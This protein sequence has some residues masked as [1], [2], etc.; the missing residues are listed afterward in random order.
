MRT[1]I[2]DMV[3]LYH[4]NAPSHMSFI[5]ANFLARSKTRYSPSPLEYQLGSVQLSSVSSTEER[6]ERKGLGDREKPP[7]ACD[8]VPESHSCQG[9]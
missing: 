4:D 7:K 3:E 8:N 1:D 6:A 2:K 5:V 9:L